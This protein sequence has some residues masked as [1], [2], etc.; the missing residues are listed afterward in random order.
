MDLSFEEQASKWKKT[1]D[2]FRHKSFKKVRL[3]PNKP[4]VTKISE[5]MEERK[6]VKMK[7][8]MAENRQQI[9]Q[10]QLQLKGL[11]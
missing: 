3:T 11:D 10:L 5:F 7:I 9:D 8:K 2:S 4:E 1:L 6:S